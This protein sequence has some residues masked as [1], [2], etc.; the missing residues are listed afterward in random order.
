MANSLIVCALSIAL[1]LLV[2]TPAGFALARG[3]FRG[4]GKLFVVIV[5]CMMVPVQ[6]IIIPEYVNLAKLGFVNTYL[7][8]VLVY[9]AIGTPFSTFLMTT[10]FRGFPEELVEAGRCDGLTFFGVFRRLAIRLAGPALATIVVLQFIPIW[11]DLLIGLIFL[12][13][14]S[15]R[16]FTVG[17]GVLESSRLVSLPGLMAAA[18]LS[19][20][21]AAT[22][23]VV[24]QR[25]LV[26]GLTLGATK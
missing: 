7:G 1:I 19:T 13:E 12:Q 23:Y 20:I 8:A 15:T 4:R 3:R 22:V 24:F 18:L 5:G 17:L 9:A 16:T 14:P 26:V 21:P 2:S 10:F 11:N 25:Y 6:S